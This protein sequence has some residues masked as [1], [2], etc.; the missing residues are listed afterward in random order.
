MVLKFVNNK[1]SLK[2]KQQSKEDHYCQGGFKTF[3]LF[4]LLICRV[5]S[6]A[7]NLNHY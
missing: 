3:K 4:C 7:T 6:V 1:L 5:W 2:S